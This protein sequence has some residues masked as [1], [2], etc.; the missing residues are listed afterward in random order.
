M[1]KI[2]IIED[3]TSDTMLVRNLC[4]DMG[5]EATIIEGGPRVVEAIQAIAPSLVM[6]NINTPLFDGLAIIIALR[7]LQP[8]N[9][10]Q[11]MIVGLNGEASTISAACR[12]AGM[13]QALTAPLQ[14]DRLLAAL[15]AIQAPLNSRIQVPEEKQNT[16]YPDTSETVLQRMAKDFG[17][18]PA[19]TPFARI[20]FVN[21][22]KLQAFFGDSW[23]DISTHIEAIT[24][25]VI[26][27]HIGESIVY[28]RFDELNFLLTAPGQTEAICTLRCQS[29]V[30]EA[31]RVLAMDEVG[32]KFQIRY[33][34][35][36]GEASTQEESATE[37]SPQSNPASS[38]NPDILPWTRLN[39]WP[40]WDTQNRK[41]SIH[42]VRAD[43]DTEGV[44]LMEAIEAIQRDGQ[45][46]YFIAI[47]ISTIANLVSRLD[48]YESLEQPRMLG[49]PV[50]FHTLVNHSTAS[51]FLYYLEQMPRKMRERLVIEIHGVPDEMHAPQIAQCQK[52]ILAHCLHT[53]IVVS[54]TYR[55]FNLL[56][57]LGNQI[58]GVELGETEA[59]LE[60][61]LK[62]LQNFGMLARQCG[63][64]MGASVV[65]NRQFRDWAMTFCRYVSGP[66]IA[67]AQTH[68]CSG[69]KLID[70]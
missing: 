13:N 29:I 27:Q 2:V 37:P 53:M 12:I 44:L 60:Q 51:R 5:F 49:L 30:K 65:R 9:N 4:R 70:I 15:R 62:A 6:I 42:A 64:S 32:T 56:K 41:F 35:F 40:V 28:K 55:S 58:V 33:V 48:G 23:P 50:H 17:S 61:E 7:A 63:L 38:I 19:E 54:P 34:T 46:N 39:F 21:F 31:C 25:E 57:K 20:H 14:P 11:M 67:L 59:D 36:F 26:E 1:Q 66:T 3:K 18:M 8:A 47:D 69:A 45:D 68:L 16:S 22:H 52:V 24:R 10:I 43:R